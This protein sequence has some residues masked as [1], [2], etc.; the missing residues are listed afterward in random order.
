[1]RSKRDHL[2]RAYL[3]RCW[4]EGKAAFGEKLRWRFSIEGVSQNQPRQGFDSLE[5]LIASVQAELDEAGGGAE[6]TA[7][8]E[9]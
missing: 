4:Q 8:Q 1:M 2:T 9:T 3:M 7:D 5:E 6:G